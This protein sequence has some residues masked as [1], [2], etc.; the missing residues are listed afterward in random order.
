[1]QGFESCA[2]NREFSNPEESEHPG[3]RGAVNPVDLGGLRDRSSLRDGL[4]WR[5]RNRRAQAGITNLREV[6]DF[7]SSVC[8]RVIEGGGLP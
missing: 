7:L 5:G 6:T 1:M 8:M 3:K 2:F 4:G